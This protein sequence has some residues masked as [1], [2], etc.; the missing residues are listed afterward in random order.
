M[1]RQVGDL[2]RECDFEVLEAIAGRSESDFPLGLVGQ[3][4]D[5]VDLTPQRRRQVDDALSCCIE[6][7]QPPTSVIYALCTVLLELARVRA[8]CLIVDDLHYSDEASI[9]FFQLL[10]RRMRRA[11]I[12]LTFA[13]TGRPMANAAMS[14]DELLTFPLTETITLTALVPGQIAEFAAARLGDRACREFATE[15]LAVSGGLPRLVSALVDDCA[16]GVTELGTGPAFTWAAGEVVRVHGPDAVRLACAAEL[17]GEPIDEVS[18]RRLLDMD[19]RTAARAAGEL[20]LGGLVV[21]GRL[22]HPAIA[23]ATL[24]EL[25]AA[26]L[27]TLRFT[28]A[29]ILNDESAPVLVVARHLIALG[30]APEPWMVGLLRDAADEAETAGEPALAKTCLTLVYRCSRDTRERS[31]VLVRLVG[32]EWLS[33]SLSAAQRAAHL[34]FALEEIRTGG[35]QATSMFRYLL[36]YGGIAEITQAWR[37]LDYGSAANVT[38]HQLTAMLVALSSYPGVIADACDGAEIP[39]VPERR[40][41]ESVLMAGPLG[42]ACFVFSEVL[43]GAATDETVA[44]AEEVLSYSR[45]SAE[46]FEQVMVALDAVLFAGRLKFAEKACERLSRQADSADAAAWR[47]Y[48]GVCRAEIALGRGDLY[49]AEAIATKA[50]DLLPRPVWSVTLGAPLGVLLSVATAKGDFDTAAELVAAPVPDGL[51]STRFG[52]RYLY[53]RGEYHRARGYVHAAL[54]DFLVCG[55]LMDRWGMDVPGVTP[56][57]LGAADAY[58]ALGKFDKA[59]RLLD[60]QELALGGRY[61]RYYAALLRLRAACSALSERL[62]LLR[63]AVEQAQAGGDQ[64]ELAKAQAALGKAHQCVGE[65]KRAQMMFRLAA[66]LAK[67]IGAKPLYE[68]LAVTSPERFGQGFDDELVDVASASTLSEAERRVAMLAATGHSNREIS[69]KLFITVSTVE[70]H[71]TRVYR[72]LKVRGR[73]DLAVELRKTN[74]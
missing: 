26:E 70:Q 54:G 39:V 24:D 30:D 31:A 66:R 57:R 73:D 17:L 62:V 53:A 3:L 2:A 65:H 64:L 55:Q 33:S 19:A 4:F 47:A 44:V 41:L 43:R 35:P 9:R 32:L 59:R 34:A 12:I 36:R 56:W 25:C 74:V 15:A 6:S 61:P 48:L 11:R 10:A 28:A 69:G 68:E 51:F 40:T 20:E 29:K 60:E 67:E 27:R 71:L 58:F 14:H 45:L 22:R 5:H 8:L 16:A 52:L 37:Q 50:L 42:R 1:L 72:K 18:V 7:T 38:E 46:S 23:K 63:R 49:A 21:D 13:S